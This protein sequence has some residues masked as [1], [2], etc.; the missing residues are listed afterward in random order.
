M[1][2]LPS[3][4]FGLVALGPASLA[5]LLPDTSRAA[6]PDDIT[7]AEN[8]DKIPAGGDDVEGGDVTPVTVATPSSGL[9]PAINDEE[10]V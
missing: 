10:K 7:E 2:G 4:V 8:I 3:I 5:L 9:P 6:L 1:S